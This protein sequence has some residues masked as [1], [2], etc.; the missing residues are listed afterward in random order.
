MLVK[1]DRSTI[2]HLVGEIGLAGRLVDDRADEL[3]PHQRPTAR[4]EKHPVLAAAHGQAGQR[5]SQFVRTRSDDLRLF[6]PR[7]LEDFRP[8]DAELRARRDDGREQLRRQPKRL[9]QGIRPGPGD[10]IVK[11][12]GTRQRHFNARD[13]AQQKIEAVGDR[14]QPAALQPAGLF[15]PQL[16]ECIARHLVNT[17]FFVNCLPR[18]FGE[19]LRHPR[20]RARIV[21]MIRRADQ[22]IVRAE[23]EV[24][25]IPGIATDTVDRLLVHADLAQSGQYLLVQM[26]DVPLQRI[27]F[28]D[29]RVLEPADFAQGEL[30]LVKG[31]QHD[32]TG[33]GTQ[34]AGNIKSIHNP[35]PS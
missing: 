6:Q 12:S 34:V 30:V 1:V 3:G 21:A 15:R 22:R 17:G 13:T 27:P 26:R 16:K 31:A 29:G 32:T 24:I 2:A 4:A 5:R 23:Q 10:R 7:F 25:G 18:H 35:W 11:L 9:E 8:Q 20:L 33:L 14:H 19:N 28:L